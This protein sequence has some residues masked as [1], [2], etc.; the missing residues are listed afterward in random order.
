[1][2]IY[3][4]YSE[5]CYGSSGYI[6]AAGSD[7]F[8]IVKEGLKHSNND[9]I[10]VYDSETMQH[11]FSCDCLHMYTDRHWCSCKECKENDETVRYLVETKQG[12][13][14]K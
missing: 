12:N 2:K 5:G 1:M 8:A 9:E 7:K 4:L 13:Y 3:I 11:L 6:I 14:C 10:E